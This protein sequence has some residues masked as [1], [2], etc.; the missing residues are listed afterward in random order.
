M[1]KS[2]I[3]LIG[4][5]DHTNEEWQALSS[6]F[7][8]LHYPHGGRATFL[9]KCRNGAF[10]NVMGLYRSNAS[11]SETGPFD[12]ELIKA[13][14]DSLKYICHNGAGY[15]TID[16]ATATK[17]GIK[18]SSTPKAVDN[19]T[20]DITIFLMLG[21]LRKA[22]VPLTA[23]RNGEWRGTTSV[24]HDPQGKVL[25]IL[26]MGGIGRVCLLH[27]YYPT[28]SIPVLIQS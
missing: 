7:T 2:A 28:W 4:T 26:G 11:T 20:A 16:V 15:D 17:R 19:A 3:L 24:G 13:L 25:G 27:T 10:D 6:D 1:H 22:M 14:P 9:E 8:L 5:L 21:A 23:L 12:A 18:I